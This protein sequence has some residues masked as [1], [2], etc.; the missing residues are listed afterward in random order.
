VTRIGILARSKPSFG[1]T[2]QYTLSMIEALK[3]IP[4]TEYTLFVSAANDAYDHLGLPMVALPSTLSVAGRLIARAWQPS[5]GLFHGV[6]KV[7]A[8][9]YSPYLLCS[10]R[11]FVFTLHDLQERHYPAYFSV[12]QRVW[13]HFMSGSMTRAATRIICESHYVKRDMMRY[14]HVD[15]RKVAVIPAPPVSAFRDVDVSPDRLAGVKEKFGLGEQFLFYPAQFW[16]H[17]NHRRLVEAFAL[18]AA[19]HEQCQLVFTGQKAWEHDRVFARVEELGLSA[20]VRHVG[21]LATAE[22]AALYKLATIVV[23]PTLFESISIPVYE[24]FLTGTPVCASNVVALPEQI[25]DAGL[26]FDPTSPADMAEKIDT[27]LRDPVLR[28]DLVRRGTERIRLLTLDRYA[29]QL[30]EVLDQVQPASP[31]V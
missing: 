17:K 3:L 22:L 31:G 25:G 9:I 8:P 11:P 30:R 10:G 28:L 13:R 4:N 15:E 16:H 21:Y 23:V 18:L 26:L 14:L 12:P 19:R 6:D 1:G 7:I 27:V 20:R 5:L 29:L 2:Y 24:A